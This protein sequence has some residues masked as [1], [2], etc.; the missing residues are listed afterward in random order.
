MLLLLRGQIALIAVLLSAMVALG[1]GVQHIG[2][3]AE[4]SAAQERAVQQRQAQLMAR[5]IELALADNDHA[6]IELLVRETQ[7]LHGV[8]SVEVATEGRGV[9][10]SARSQ[11]PKKLPSWARW[12]LVRIQPELVQPQS[13]SAPIMDAERKPIGTVSI[14]LQPQSQSMPIRRLVSSIISLGALL[15][16]AAGVLA[17]WTS[18]RLT[19]GLGGMSEVIVAYTRGEVQMR[20]MR[21]GSR[22]IASIVDRLNLLG[23]TLEQLHDRADSAAED[24]TFI[25]KVL[26]S[27]ADSL[28]VVDEDAKIQKINRATLELLGYEEEE[29]IGRTASLI[30]L[31]DGFHLTGARLAH[32][33]GQEVKRDHEVTYIAKD[34]RY[35]PISLSGSAIRDADD[36]VSG[37]V[38]IGTDIT[39]RKRSD[40]ERE[41][42][43]RKLVSTSRQAGMAEV[44]TGVLHNVGNVLNSVNVTAGLIEDAIRKSKTGRIGE[45]AR[46]L[47]QHEENLGDFVVDDERGR[48]LP[49]Y[50]GKL[51]EHLDS[52]QQRMLQQMQS[53]NEHISHMKDII[54]VQQS[55]SKVIGVVEPIDPRE[56]MED[57]LRMS[58]AAKDRHQIRIVRE[59]DEVGSLMADR[60]K[61]LQILVNLVNNAVE[62]MDEMRGRTP[63]LT[64]VVRDEPGEHRVRLDVIDNGIGI[65][66]KQVKRV[67]THG[68]TTKKDGHGFGLHSAAVTAKEIGGSLSAMS[69][70]KGSGAK[71]TLWLTRKPGEGRKAA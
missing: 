30:C 24:N 68:F 67:F 60:H 64:L 63:I 28:M 10:A 33:L 11:A 62:A 44:A 22:P 18:G 3:Q 19:R 55:V 13:I 46:L 1:M 37:Y 71:F 14:V 34:G 29:L 41:E 56:I 6:A 4:W 59:F 40:T 15:S 61:V 51:S 57:A 8:A 20:V 53:L 54:R 43:Q 25:N 69:D 48:A 45:L 7:Q 5:T 17:F 70:G 38:C 39:E 2:R 66:P 32:L 27:M 65:E 16:I 23:E 42:L 58:S 26:Q 31:A 12:A 35:I 52:E 9:V 50:M 49:A 36:N 47:A 21:T